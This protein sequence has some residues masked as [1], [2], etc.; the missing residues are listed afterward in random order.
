[1]TELRYPHGYT[2]APGTIFPKITLDRADGIHWEDYLAA[3][4]PVELRS[5][6]HYKREDY[7]APLGYGGINGS[8]LRQLIYLIAGEYLD[9]LGSGPKV[10]QPQILTG[11]SVL[12]P[13][14]SM[15]ALVARHYRIPSTIIL[16][17]T[18]PETCTRHENVAIAARAGA[19]FRFNPVGFNPALQRAVRDLHAAPEFVDAYRL[20]YGITT[21]DNEGP[22]AV[23][24]FHAWGALQTAN[25]PAGVK[26]LVMTA[27]SCNSC[28][29]VLYGLALHRPKN[30]ERIVLLGVGPTRLQWIEDR[31][32]ALEQAMDD[33][34]VLRDLFRRR[35]HHHAAL[36]AEHQ[37]DG[38][39]LI[40]HY[41]L[42]STGYAT[43]QD[44]MPW[45]L[46]GID[47]HPT[48]EGKALRYMMERQGEFGWFWD[49]ADDVLF[50]IVGSAPSL[51]A[52]S[53]ALLLDGC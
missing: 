28:V 25:I 14:V 45:S 1:M 39:L 20:C 8:K 30:L 49:A 10:K 53:D 51:R 9:L 15:T 38:P 23:K 24:R 31:L 27:G 46:D 4:T 17:A 42:H 48:Y 11:A 19:E 47:F 37:T 52:M 7:F 50:W 16:G 36:E 29:S 6:V 34:F 21:P 35:Y 22:E 26:T 12:S 40:E 44:K 3:L 41:D 32:A 18:S 5:G 43:Y 13:Q 33:Q 2:A